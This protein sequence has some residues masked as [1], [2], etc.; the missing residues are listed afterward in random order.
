MRNKSYKR[1]LTMFLIALLVLSLVACTGTSSEDTGQD[2]SQDTSQETPQTN[3]E[4]GTEDNEEPAD[5]QEVVTLRMIIRVNAE[6]V[7]EGNPIIE[8][9]ERR[10]NTKLEIEAPPINNYN[11]RLNIVMASGDLPDIIYLGNTGTL[12]AN[13]A[14]DGL[15]LKLDEYFEKSMPNAKKVLTEEELA[16]TR[17]TEL[18]NG[19]YSLPRVQT[20][21]WDNIIYRK[22]W[23]EA[24]G[25]EIPATPKEFAEVMLA[26][27]KNDPDGNG[28]DDTYGWS[29][30]RAMGHLHRNLIGGFNIRPNS[31]PDENGN[32]ELVQAQE[33][34]MQ[35]I[36]WLR[37][38]YMNG[39]MDP[40]WYLTKYAEDDEK[41]NAGKLGAVYTNK[42]TEHMTSQTLNQ[43]KKT[44][45]KAE[46]V[47]G[48]PL[49]PEG[50]TVSDVYYQPQIWGNWGI[51]ADS[52]HIDRAVAFLDYGYTDEC[53][54][55]LVIGME[56]VTY[57]SFDP[58]T[59]FALRT[60]EQQ[61]A[62]SKY[63]STYASINFQCADKGLLFVPGSTE[64]EFNIFMQAYDDI[65]KQT[66]RITYL[67]ESILPGI[68]DALVKIE[69]SGIPTKYEE[70]ETKYICG[71]ISREEFVN[72]IQNEYIP[73][74]EEYMN[75]IRNSG[76]NK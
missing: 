34:Y 15:L 2:T 42:I 10:T 66:N 1:V 44:D 36:D 43:V 3:E 56:G 58:K 50:K 23:L 54:E 5:S 72:F 70:Y 55:L 41:W 25:L 74:Y 4:T 64:E 19:L 73:A 35:F 21:P 38:M 17:V 20:K 9:L 45:A 24:L 60:P 33:G 69:D 71:Q 68:R 63:T 47:A 16:F 40:E 53:N 51:S 7:V 67:P 52:E 76:I 46:L 48:P 31:V 29:Y 18:D 14:K 32:Y 26:F 11:D 39:S 27:A 75:I 13:W 61:E 22:D 28:K 59:R 49:R 62:T 65:G 37:E 8:E 30:N 6:Y 57:T 12:Y